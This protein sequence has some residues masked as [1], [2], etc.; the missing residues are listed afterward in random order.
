MKSYVIDFIG[1]IE[2]EAESEADAIY[3]A[4][5]MICMAGGADSCEVS[6]VEEIDD[7][8]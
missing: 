7:E 2:I 4:C 1:T 6:C 5:N 8:D 3:E